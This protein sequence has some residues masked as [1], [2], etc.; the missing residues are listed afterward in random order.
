MDLHGMADRVLTE[1]DY[2]DRMIEHMDLDSEDSVSMT[3][4]QAKRCRRECQTYL[5]ALAAHRDQLQ[6]QEAT[7]E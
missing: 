7:S 6:A 5:R 4:A 3:L 2:L 1:F